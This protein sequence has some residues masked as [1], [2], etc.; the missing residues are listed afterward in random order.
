MGRGRSRGTRRR[1]RLCGTGRTS[2]LLAA[3]SLQGP[4]ADHETIICRGSSAPPAKAYRGQPLLLSSPWAL[5]RLRL[6]L[7][8]SHVHG[9]ATS[10]PAWS[11]LLHSR[12]RE[13]SS[14]TYGDERLPFL[15]S[16]LK[17]LNIWCRDQ[18]GWME[19]TDPRGPV[20]TLVQIG[21]ANVGL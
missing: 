14:S 15:P 13:C 18:L 19:P 21:P 2:S 3:G 5:L 8:F 9:R 7:L 6:R 12:W 10:I 16:T 11:P 1:R 17:F 20:A 4:D